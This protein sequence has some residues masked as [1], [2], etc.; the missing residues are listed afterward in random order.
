M[1][2]SLAARSAGNVP[3]TT[4]ILTAE[5]IEML[6]TDRTPPFDLAPFAIERFN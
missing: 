4:P 6:A 2:E 1:G 5:A 3:N